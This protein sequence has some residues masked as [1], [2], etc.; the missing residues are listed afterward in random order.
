MIA[1][2]YISIF[3]IF[4]ILTVAVHKTVIKPNML[5]NVMW[6]TGGG[7]VSC[8]YAGLYQLSNTT[9]LYIVTS[10][11]IFNVVYLLMGKKN[12]VVNLEEQINLWEIKWKRIY[13]LNI[14]CYFFMFPIVIKAVK[15]IR[16]QGWDALR[17]YAFVGSAELVSA[18]QIRV[19]SWVIYPIFLSTI[20]LAIIF[21]VKKG[22]CLKLYIIAII[23]LTIYTISFGGRYDIVKAIVY[24]VLVYIVINSTGDRKIKIPL[25]YKIGALVTIILTGYLTSLRSLK[26]LSFV[27]NAAVYFFGSFTYFDVV[28]N[29]YKYVTNHS[30]Y[31]YGTG[32][33]GF[34][35]N[36]IIYVSSIIF[37]TPN[38]TSEYLTK[39]VTDNYEFIGYGLRYNAM[40]SALYPFWRDG[41][42]AGIAF[43]MSIFAL[44]IVYFERRFIKVHNL[45]SLALYIFVLF[46]LFS[47]TMVYDLLTIRTSINILF[48]FLFTS[49]H[50]TQ[51]DIGRR[52][53]K[54]A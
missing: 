16:I 31:T 23:N 19:V 42:L 40:S 12:E 29:S 45:R 33:L 51:N 49:S 43:G 22:K 13:R 47:S 17:R 2:M 15:I 52:S 46:V 14:L 21:V 27:Q 44:I 9:N 34:V 48:I 20:L 10:I 32:V 18:L 1:V 5:F 11:V 30:I 54:D 4:T 26:G 37:K 25:V 35:L 41:R 36:P 38:F 8:G 39:L 53:V 28:V 6:C 50:R 7:L 24:F 3:C